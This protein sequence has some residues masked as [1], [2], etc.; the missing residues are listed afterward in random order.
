MSIQCFNAWAWSE[1]LCV[2]LTECLESSTR[3]LQVSSFISPSGDTPLSLAE[4]CGH[5]LDPSCLSPCSR[6]EAEASGLFYASSATSQTPCLWSSSLSSKPPPPIFSKHL[7]QKFSQHLLALFPHNLL[8][9]Q[10]KVSLSHSL[11]DGKDGGLV[12]FSSQHQACRRG[13]ISISQSHYLRAN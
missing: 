13:P 1:I 8:L 2:I 10:Y 7:L 4:C 9:P 5:S 3:T 6:R 12:T 11:K